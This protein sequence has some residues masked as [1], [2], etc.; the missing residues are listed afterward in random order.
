MIFFFKKRGKLKSEGKER[1]LCHEQRAQLCVGHE[2]T[3]HEDKIVHCWVWQRERKRTESGGKSN[4]KRKEVR[5][6]EREVPLYLGFNH[7]SGLRCCYFSFKSVTWFT[8][9]YVH[10]HRLQEVLKDLLGCS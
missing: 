6:S 5:G 10:S 3:V 2:D 7:L 4:G 1:I 8:G 9:M